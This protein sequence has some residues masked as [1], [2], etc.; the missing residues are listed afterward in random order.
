MGLQW[1]T[2]APNP[3]SAATGHDAGQRGWRLHAVTAD[4]TATFASLGRMRAL[5]GLRPS[6]GWGL[7]LFISDDDRCRRCERAAGLPPSSTNVARN[8]VRFSEPAR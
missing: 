1:L 4:P 2:T 3:A 5:C 6:H 7:D 8:R